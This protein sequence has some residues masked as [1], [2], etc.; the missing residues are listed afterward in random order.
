MRIT[1]IVTVLCLVAVART[2]AAA[3][4]S[5]FKANVADSIANQGLRHHEIKGSET[6]RYAAGVIRRADE[7]KIEDKKEKKLP[8]KDAEKEVDKSKGDDKKKGTPA[9]PTSDPLSSYSSPLWMVQPYSASVWEQGRDYVISWGPNP[10]PAHSKSLEDHAPVDILL[11]QG[12]PDLLKEVFVI[13]KAVNSSAHSFVWKI[14][15]DLAPAI[16][17]TVRLSHNGSVDTYSHFF[18]VSKV[19]DPRS[20]KS[21]VGEPLVMPQLGAVPLPKATIIQPVA[22]PNPFPDDKTATHSDAK[23]P[24]TTPAAHTSSSIE[25]KSANMLGF[26]MALFGA[27]YFL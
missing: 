6:S 23:S 8:K 13:G 11:M 5:D 18:E 17:Y 25:T 27:V 19:G 21:N 26:A 16:D 7:G 12:P 20:T 1:P 3:D 4:R 10:D 2:T 22:P 15:A 9:A 24:S 14:P